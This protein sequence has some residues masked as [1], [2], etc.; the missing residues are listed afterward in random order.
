MVTSKQQFTPFLMFFGKAEEAMNFYVSLFDQSEVVSIQRY[1]PD[2]PGAEGSVLHATFLL[3]GQQ[4]MCIDSSEKHDFTFTP[5]LSI[6]VTCQSD[7]EIDRLFQ[8]LSE[9]GAVLMPLD[10][11]PFSERYGWVSDRYGVSWQL[12]LNRE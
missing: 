6:F 11:Y 4:F 12:T 1:G 10:A 2:G 8:R 3:G 7:D 5:A 9:D